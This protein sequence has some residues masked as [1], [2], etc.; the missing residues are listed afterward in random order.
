MITLA[1]VYRNSQHSA[2]P[3]IRE[4]L[5]SRFFDTIVYICTISHTMTLH[6]AVQFI[7]L[8][9]P[10]GK[11][12][13]FNIILSPDAIKVVR[14]LHSFRTHYFI[15]SRREQDCLFHWVWF[16]HAVCLERALVLCMQ[17]DEMTTTIVGL[18]SLGVSFYDGPDCSAAVD[19]RSRLLLSEL[20]TFCFYRTRCTSVRFRI[21]AHFSLLARAE[22]EIR[23]KVVHANR[24]N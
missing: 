18:S 20:K 10:V 8:A 21:F 5:F 4:K 3:V 16:E 15:C 19:R 7:N 2:A 24:T 1:R 6:N 13:M 9:F 17:R 11:R 12:T 14:P 22:H 23:R